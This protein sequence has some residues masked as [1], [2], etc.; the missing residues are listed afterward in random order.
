MLLLAML[1][2]VLLPEIAPPANTA[3]AQN[4]ARECALVVFFAHVLGICGQGRER[5]VLVL[6]TARQLL[7]CLVA[8]LG[9]VSV[10]AGREYICEPRLGCCR[11]VRSSFVDFMMVI[12]ADMLHEMIFA[13][14]SIST[15]MTFAILAGV[16]GIISAK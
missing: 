5:L 10:R 15:S 11:C 6:N 4:I 2:Q 12:I 16:W 9:T 1:K 14:E 13:S 7:E 8:V 3:A